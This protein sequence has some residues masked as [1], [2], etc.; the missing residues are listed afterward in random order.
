MGGLDVKEEEE[1][2]EEQEQEEMV[3]CSVLGGRRFEGGDE[4]NPPYGSWGPL[5]DP[6][7]PQKP[8][9]P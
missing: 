3:F 2:V 6:Q 8:P 7:V 4:A 5:C 9:N 1:E